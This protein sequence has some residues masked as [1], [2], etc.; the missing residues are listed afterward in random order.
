MGVVFRAEHRLMERVVALKILNKTLTSKPNAVDRF[1]QE[2]KMAA[3]LSHPNIVAAYDADQAGEVHFLITEFVEG[4]SLD[5]LLCERGAVSIP[6]ACD[7][8][9]QAALGLQ[10]AVERGM[11]HRDIKPAN[12][13][14]T[15]QG[16]IKILDFGLA[17]FM[18]ESAGAAP[19]TQSATLVGTPDY[20]AP[21]QAR[22]PRS[23]DI[24]ADIYSLGCTLYH[25]LT[26]RPPFPDGTLLQKL[27]SHQ[28][29]TPTAVQFLRPDVPD[30]LASVVE[31]MMAKQRE[32]RYATPQEVVQALTPFVSNAGPQYAEIAPPSSRRLGWLLGGLG[33]ALAASIVIVIIFYNQKN[34][35]EQKQAAAAPGVE[36]NR[37]GGDPVAPKAPPPKVEP[38]PAPAPEPKITLPDP[39][40]APVDPLVEWVRHNN[41]FGAQHIV[42]RDAARKRDEA[43]TRGFMF[44]LGSGMVRSGRT[45]VLTSIHKSFFVIELPK[46]PA[47]A[48]PPLGTLSHTVSTANEKMSADPQFQL[49]NPTIDSFKAIKADQPITGKVA[50]RRLHKGSGL[51]ALR[52][53]YVLGKNTYTQ[54]SHIFENLDDPQGERAFTFPKMNE[55][56][57]KRSGPLV[58]L[59][60]LCRFDGPDRRGAVLVESNVVPAVVNLVPP[61]DVKALP[62]IEY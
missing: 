33:A 1:R 14:L 45:T 39:V 13:L 62:A 37:P 23:A 40:A 32:E 58:L 11:V 3:K 43:G 59:I 29:M 16:Q 41:K 36:Q 10:H 47:T 9:R 49:G 61:P 24:R 25:L 52:M 48:L 22:E 6:E 46:E 26:G 51:Y 7:W 42:V 8:V 60:D 4:T 12:L 54:Y 21:E 44:Y 20:V 5:R 34:P 35:G 28:E 27:I 53:K 2:V 30:A 17:R 19:L 18:S 50:V 55:D 56:A 57:L 38:D 15:R 31:R